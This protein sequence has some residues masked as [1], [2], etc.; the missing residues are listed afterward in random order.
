MAP[1]LHL[2]DAN[3]GT[4]V[5][6]TRAAGS[7][8]LRV[9]VDLPRP[10]DEPT[11]SQLRALV[12]ADVLRRAAE[13]VHAAQTVVALAVPGGSG[14]PMSLALLPILHALQVPPPD[15]MAQ[16]A[17]AATRKLGAQPDIWITLA[18][19]ARPGPGDDPQ[20]AVRL[21]IGDVDASADA[22]TLPDLLETSASALRLALLA[23]DRATPIKL[24][25]ASVDRAREWLHTLRRDMARWAHLPSAAIPAP[26]QT[27]ITGFLDDDLDVPGLLAFL[28]D[29]AADPAVAD[30]AKFE[31]LAFADR[32]LA[33]D[34][35]AGLAGTGA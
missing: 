29:I 33:L 13:A 2:T 6:V 1:L 27:A 10:A 15:V 32:M 31:A 11:F 22:P 17:E 16:S 35:T 14:A 4:R 24:T 9:G 34:L 3:S 8:L 25:K 21:A 28:H 19:A 7:R 18:S 23:D 30:G 20:P 26:V 12:V 5:P